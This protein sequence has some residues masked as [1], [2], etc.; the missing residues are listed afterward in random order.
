MFM[1]HAYAIGHTDRET[2]NMDAHP[3]DD[4][5]FVYSALRRSWASQRALGLLIVV[6]RVLLLGR[7]NG[8]LGWRR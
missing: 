7:S 6:I 1:C 4:S 3:Y 2:R 8:R 5:V